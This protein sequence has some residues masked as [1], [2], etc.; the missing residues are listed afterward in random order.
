[1]PPFSRSLAIALL[2]V[3]ATGDGVWAANPK[4]IHSK[5]SSTAPS[6]PTAYHPRPLKVAPASKGRQPVVKT[7]TT[8]IH[9][10]RSQ[11]GKVTV[12]RK[13]VHGR[14]VRVTHLG[15]PAGPTYQTHPDPDRYKEIQQA[16]TSN[17]Y[18]KGEA[19]GQWGDDSVAALKQ[20]QTEHN[21]PNDGKV[22][23]LSLIGLGLG[24]HREVPQAA[25]Q[26]APV[27]MPVSLPASPTTTTATTPPPPPV[28]PSQN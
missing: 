2:T 17:G 25:A 26:G 1:M 20:F 12:T 24:P 27:P 19:N 7:A 11:N 10:S 14:W 3:L 9:R 22:N 6:K 18:F 15:R 8:P 23:S 21:L 28:T 13:K 16:L 5:S 4:K